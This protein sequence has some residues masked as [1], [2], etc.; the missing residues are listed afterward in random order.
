MKSLLC[1][2]IIVLSAFAPN[3]TA[4]VL[5]SRCPL[6]STPDFTSSIVQY[7]E[8]D[9]FLSQ[10][11]Q[12][13]VLGTEGDFVLVKTSEN[14]E[15]YVYK[16]YLTQNT[17]QETYPVFNCSVRE[18]CL[19][20][21]LEKNPTTYVAEKNQRVFIYNGF[22]NVEGGYTEVQLVLA[23]GSLYNGLIKSSSLRP[24]GVNRNAIIAIPIIL[25]GITVVL[26]IVFIGKKKKKRKKLAVKIEK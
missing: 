16:Y 25:A 9:Y 3:S 20:Y 14:V 22:D 24:D 2:A 18:N 26:S 12:V 10:N 7:E 19:V 23:D 6:Y 13:E 21:D 11:D 4:F 15:G 1:I 17:S 8:T 5:A